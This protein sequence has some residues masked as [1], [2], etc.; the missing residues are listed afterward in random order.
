MRGRYASE[1]QWGERW[2][3]AELRD[4]LRAVD[5]VCDAPD[6]LGWKPTGGVGTGEDDEYDAEED[7]F[8]FGEGSTDAA[9]GGRRGGMGEDDDGGAGGGVPPAAEAVMDGVR[10]STA[11]ALSLPAAA[12]LSNRFSG[13]G[14]DDDDDGG[15]GGVGGAGGVSA[16]VSYLSNVAAAVVDDFVGRLRRRVAAGDA[17]G[18]LAIGSGREVGG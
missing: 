18:A 1:P 13:F 14:D 17:F 11:R 4:C 15:G 16:R 6:D 8:F 5:I 12:H 9:A 7:A 2:M 3:E 10:R